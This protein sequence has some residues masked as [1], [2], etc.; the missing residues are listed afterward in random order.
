MGRKW[1]GESDRNE[2]KKRFRV[3]RTIV[4]VAIIAITPVNSTSVR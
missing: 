4:E 1:D 3:D 2:K